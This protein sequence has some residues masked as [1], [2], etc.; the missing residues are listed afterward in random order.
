MVHDIRTP[1]STL[2]M[3]LQSTMEIPEEKR[4]TLRNAAITI[5]D[6][7]GDLLR[8][9]E[10]TTNVS[11][12]GRQIVLVSTL[13]A[14]VIGDRRHKYRDLAIK[15]DYEINQ[16]NAFTFIKVEAL[17]F[18]RAISNL[19]NNAVEALPAKGG[20]IKLRLDYLP[21]VVKILIEDNGSGIPD[22]VLDKIN[23]RELIT[24]GKQNG[25]GLGLSVVYDMLERNHGEIEIYSAT[26]SDS[27]DGSGTTI[28]LKFPTVTTPDWVLDEI[29]LLKDNIVVILD[30]DSSIHKGWD[31][32]LSYILEKI[33]TLTVKHFTNG[34][35]A[36]AFIENLSAA[37]KEKVYLMSDYE[38]I[39]QELNGL[40][41]IAQAEIN[42]YM[43]VT[44]HYA[45]ISVRKTAS[46]NNVKIL[47]KD[48]VHIVPIKVVQESNEAVHVHM[49]FVD[50]VASFTRELVTNYYSHLLV[51]S[52]TNPLKFLAEFKKYA[53]DTI[54]VLDNMYSMEDN[55]LYEVDGID[56]ARQ[57][58]ANG[59][60]QL[61]LLSGEQIKTPEYVKFVLKNDQDGIAKLNKMF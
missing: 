26:E 59:Y 8:Q 61:I 60:T 17:D 25:H 54:F 29:N 49:V 11:N 3:T 44:S 41:I 55:S 16:E 34:V 53:K 56:L 10:P 15:F 9:Y 47:P 38:L 4:L 1:L 45:N 42:R 33:T 22:E 30:D 48:L 58:Y 24:H 27:Y 13:L 37:D 12:E 40:E 31:S 46:Q 57:L 5:T 32:R 7:A 14:S 23:N 6:I 52:Y 35:E 51:E 50:D 43:L 28:Q 19:I 2:Q 21:G 39:G 20:I 36:L 18:K